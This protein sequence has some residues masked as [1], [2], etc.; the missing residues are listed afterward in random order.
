MSGCDIIGIGSVSIDELLSIKRHP[1][2]DGKAKVL[3]RGRAFGGL[4][5]TALVAAARLGAR[6]AYAGRLGLDEDSVAVAEN[7]RRRGVEIGLAVRDA[8][9]GVVRSVIAV[10]SDP[11]GRSILYHLTGEIGAHPQLP[12]EADLAGAKV[13]LCDVNGLEGSIRAARLARSHGVAVV[14][15]LEID[16]GRKPQLQALVDEVDHLILSEQDAS[17]LCG[18]QDPATCL[19]RLWSARRTLVAVTCGVRGCWWS[20]AAGVVRH[21]AA[22]AV[23]TRDSTGCGDVFHGA[24]AEALARSRPLEECLRW[25]AAAAAL[26]ASGPAGQDGCPEAHQ[27]ISLINQQAPALHGDRRARTH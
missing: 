27:V 3:S 23:A 9:S 19:S 26:K 10:S 1:G 15:D 5:G 6:C 12:S 2:A 20:D 24:Y 16:A 7:L 18:V 4:T 13:L 8:T 14:G 21:Q 17:E 22:F 11:P 25:A